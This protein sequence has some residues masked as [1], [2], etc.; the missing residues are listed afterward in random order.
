[1]KKKNSKLDLLDNS[2]SS[3]ANL[4]YIRLICIMKKKPMF[5]LQIFD[6]K[7]II[8]ILNH[9]FEIGLVIY[10]YGTSL[11]FIQQNLLFI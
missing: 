5:I 9:N 8:I 6:K 4:E 1:M 7:F 11:Y 2:N 3:N 10:L